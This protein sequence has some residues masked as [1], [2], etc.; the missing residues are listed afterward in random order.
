[1]DTENFVVNNGCEGEIIE[2][3]SAVAPDIDTS[4]LAEA[5]VV[6]TI[7]LRDLTRF[8]VSTDQSDAFWVSD[9]KGEQ[10]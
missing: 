3:L 4:I 2:D 10:K 7:N 1:M 8:M 5:F 9:L 6:E